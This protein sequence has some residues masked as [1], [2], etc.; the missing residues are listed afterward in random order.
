MNLLDGLNLA[1]LEAATS[2]SRSILTIAGPGSGKTK[3]LIT[4]IAHL[5][6]ERGQSSSNILCLTFTR[7]AAQEMKER[8]AKLL[9]ERESSRIWIGT[10]HAI[11]LRILEQFGSKIGYS[12]HISVYDEIDQEDIIK[13]ILHEFSMK[14]K[15]S[16]VIK[17]L[18]EYAADCDGSKFSQEIATIVAEYRNRL[19]SFNAVDYSLLLTET[20]YLLRMHRDVFEYFNNR[21]QHVLIDEYQDTDRTQFYLHEALKPANIFCVGDFDQLLYSWRGS[22]ISII[23]DFEKNHEDAQ[24]IRLEQSY[25]C[26]ANIIH[27]ANNLIGNNPRPY[28]KELWT[29]NAPGEYLETGFNIRDDEAMFISQVASTKHK[30]DG[31]QYGEMA[32]LVRTHDQYAEIVNRLALDGVPHKVV[33]AQMNFWKTAGARMVVAVLKYLH[34]TKDTYQFQNVVKNV[35]YRLTSSE[36]LEYEAKAAKCGMRVSDLVMEERPGDFKEL[37]EFFELSRERPLAEIIL[38][39]TDILDIVGY[40]LERSLTTKA[41]D[42]ASLYTNAIEWQDLNPQNPTVESFLEWT[43]ERDTQLEVDESNTVKIMTIHA[44]K[45]LE[46]SVVFLAGMNEGKLPHKRSIK[47]NDIEEERRIAYVAITRAKNRLYITHTAME[48]QGMRLIEVRP[49]RFIQEMSVTEKELAA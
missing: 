10:F 12:K 3:T 6:E 11:S 36:W 1:Q 29:K 30:L 14:T 39:V 22:D 32:V 48:P 23:E 9:G 4:R 17:A 45:G 38:H 18:N 25:R 34:N 42:I 16:E 35:V 8:L 33:G 27:M 46:F 5:I 13:S 20:L 37:Q 44:A 7:K 21:F 31:V 15:P 2:T 40:F 19:K 28:E 41:N 24:V 47:A 43:T 26:P 49:S